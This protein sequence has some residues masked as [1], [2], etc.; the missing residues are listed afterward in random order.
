MATLGEE[1]RIEEGGF[2]L[3]SAVNDHVLDV[4][5]ADPKPGAQVVASK[6]REE[7]EPHQLWYLDELGLLRSRLNGFALEVHENK[8]KFHL[9]PYTG[10]ARQQWRIEGNRIVNK[11]FCNE[12]VDMKK[13]LLK[14]DNSDVIATPYEGKDHQHWRV[15]NI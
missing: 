7:R 6:R 10:D 9:K 1:M 15:E 3:I 13:G 11:V 2:Y 8:D 4:H 5:K 12:C 14:H